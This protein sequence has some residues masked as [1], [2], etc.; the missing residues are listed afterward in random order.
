MSRF[1]STRRLLTA[2]A[3]SLAMTALTVAQVFAGDGGPPYPK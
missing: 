1:Q 3:F 2:L